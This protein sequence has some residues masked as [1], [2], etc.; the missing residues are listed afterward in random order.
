MTTPQKQRKAEPKAEQPRLDEMMR[1]LEELR[2]GENTQRLIASF[3][4]KSYKADAER[5]DKLAWILSFAKSIGQD[6]ADWYFTAISETKAVAE[7]TDERVLSF[8]K[9]IGRDAVYQYFWVIGETKAVAELT[10]E[11]VLSFA[12]SIDPDAAYQYFRAIRNTKAVAELTDE[13]VLSFAKSSGAEAVREY[14]KRMVALDAVDEFTDPAFLDWYAKLETKPFPVRFAKPLLTKAFA[15]VREGSMKEWEVLPVFRWMGESAIPQLL[16]KARGESM[17]EKILAGS[18]LYAIGGPFV[19]SVRDEL[20][21]VLQDAY[22]TSMETREHSKRNMDIARTL[23][24]RLEMEFGEGNVLVTVIGST[25]KSLATKESD[26]D[27]NV[28]I[29]SDRPYAE[30]DAHSIADELSKASGVQL[31][32]SI[33]VFPSTDRVKEVLAK[34]TT[35]AT[36]SPYLV[37]YGDLKA[38]GEIWLAASAIRSFE[39]SIMK[40][41]YG[42]RAMTD[43]KRAELFVEAGKYA[44]AVKIYEYLLT[45]YPKDE[46]L[47]RLL[48]EARLKQ[49]ESRNG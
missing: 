48:E 43:L 10:D 3:L 26:I 6:A 39:G 35:P 45:H 30:K 19:E 33:I 8:A 36:V 14:F 17:N 28:Y 2:C 42:D 13:Q 41:K 32:P 40:E 18:A 49:G 4:D 27:C 12:K 7:L 21:A 1:Q 25:Q 16:E 9:S 5:A 38:A 44:E 23:G 47:R 15:A 37:A 29:F 31:S 24:K 22:P 20:E 11:R 34:G 46:N